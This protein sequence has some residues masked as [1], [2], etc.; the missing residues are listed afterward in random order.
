MTL[1]SGWRVGLEVVMVVVGASW[2]IFSE[3]SSLSMRIERCA[4]F[5][6]MLLAFGSGLALTDRFERGAQGVALHLP[7]GRGGFSGS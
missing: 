4:F 6:M 7:S 5:S 2:N 1:G 3:P